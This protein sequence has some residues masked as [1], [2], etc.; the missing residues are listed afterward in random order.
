VHN[1]VRKFASRKKDEEFLAKGTSFVDPLLLPHEDLFTDSSSSLSI[2]YADRGV[3]IVRDSGCAVNLRGPVI[4]ST[5]VR[6]FLMHSKC[7]S[8]GTS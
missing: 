6:S 1:D 3:Y 2:E 5:L 4:I 8:L 7:L